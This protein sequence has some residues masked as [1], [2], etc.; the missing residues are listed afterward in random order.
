MRVVHV[1]HTDSFAG[2]ER[3]AS[4]LAASQAAS[5]HEVTVI[6]GRQ[7]AVRAAVGD[8]RVTLLEAG[9]LPHL[10]RMLRSRLDSDIF[11][12]H[13]TE[14]EGAA[15]LAD[16]SGRAPIVTTR[17]FAAIRGTTLA[18]HLARPLIRRRVSAQIAVSRF[19]AERVD[20]PATVVYPGVAVRADVDPARRRRAVL[21]A[22][23]LE[24]EKDTELGLEA[25][26]ES[27]LARKGWTLEI[28]G[29]GRL[30]S[31]L[32]ARAAVLGV[33]DA[34]R[35]RGF[36]TDMDEALASCGILLATAP[37]EHFGLTVL[38][39]MSWG[40]PVVAAA[41]AAHLETAGSASDVGLFEAGDG[42]AAADALRRLA[43]DSELRRSYGALLADV[44]RRSFTLESQA[45]GVERVYRG[46]L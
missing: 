34:V 38:E 31:A 13:M 4:V 14:A 10:V 6:G 19:V 37:G 2:V 27:G 18:G 21:L 28:A 42:H 29:E 1:I 8:E 17:H 12:V 35:F 43:D 44:Q 5:G 20:G 40:T 3:Y 9:S 16:W 30:R 25:F 32:E 45:A 11:H 33:P 24:R 15:A 7:S 41:A 23:R 39:A 46:V 26:V 36:V 22:Q